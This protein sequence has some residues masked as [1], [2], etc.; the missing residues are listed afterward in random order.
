M[1]KKY[2]VNPL[3][4]E[5]V[6]VILV[7]Y[8][9]AHCLHAQSLK[10]GKQVHILL[11]DNGSQDDF[12]AQRSQHMPQ[13]RLIELPS[14]IG[15]GAANNRALKL[16]ATPFALLLNPDCQIDPAG[17]ERLLAVALQY[18]DAAI[19]APQITR[20][21]GELEVSYRWPSKTWASQG[22]AAQAHCCVGFATG[23]ALLLRLEAFEDT[24]FFDESFFLYYEDEDLCLR[25]FLA[26]RSIVIAP[27]VHAVHASRS[28]V[29]EGFP[30]RSEYIR[31]F[32]HAQSKLIFQAKH[33]HVDK[34]QALRWR[35]LLLALLSVPIRLLWPQP[36]YLVRLFG[37]IAGLV[38][39]RLPYTLKA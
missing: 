36:R 37:R 39:Y 14:N 1:Q 22:P 15:F 8:N 7:T 27:E 11:V 18:P 23:A 13:A 24:G 3:L 5:H 12:A 16:C 4:L 6:T 33:G 9:S 29:K 34:V 35:V 25:Q 20:P 17:I 32:H 19:V 38:R 2:P 21:C 28:S 31:G 30:W 26:R 10:L